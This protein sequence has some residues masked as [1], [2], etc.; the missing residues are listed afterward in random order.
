MELL[1]LL[2]LR[3]PMN[4]VLCL[5][6]QILGTYDA[7]RLMRHYNIN[8]GKKTRKNDDWQNIFYL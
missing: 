5:L 1:P 3:P 6:N 4:Q 7:F 8:F 2:V